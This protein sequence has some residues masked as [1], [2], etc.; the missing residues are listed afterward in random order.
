M[1]KPAGIRTL[2]PAD[3]TINLGW[4]GRRRNGFI[5]RIVIQS[6]FGGRGSARTLARRLRRWF[7][8]GGRSSDWGGLLESCGMSELICTTWTW[9]AAWEWAI[10]T[11]SHLPEQRTR[12][13]FRGWWASLGCTLFLSRG[14]GSFL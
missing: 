12:S 7:H 14:G 9:E 2:Q 11:R 5:L 10:P 1:C 13:W 4:I 6:G 8:F 3:T